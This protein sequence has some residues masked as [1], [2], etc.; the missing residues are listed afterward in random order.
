MISD[1]EL[2]R[3]LR[4]WL[5]E[6]AERAPMDRVTAALEEIEHVSQRRSRRAWLGRTFGLG[7]EA[8]EASRRPRST[9][10][11]LL[12]AMIVVALAMAVAIGLGGSRPPRPPSPTIRPTAPPAADARV[13]SD[14]PF[15]RIG[16]TALDPASSVYPS[17]SFDGTLLGYRGDAWWQ[18]QDG[19]TWTPADRT[20]FGMGGTLVP[21]G[22]GALSVVSNDGGG[23]T[24]G[25][26]SFREVLH[27]GYEADPDA[28]IFRRDGAGWSKLDIP[29]L[30][31]AVP[32][33]L[34]VLGPGFRMLGSTKHEWSVA[35]GD[36]KWVVPA[37]HVLKVDWNSILDIPGDE[38][39]PI[40]R[41]ERGGMLRIYRPGLDTDPL[42]E[43]SVQVVAGDPPSIEF[44]DLASGAVVHR[45][46]A[47]LR[48]WTPDEL[49]TAV[50]GWGAIDVS[51]VVASDGRIQV[52]HPPWPPTE[53][54][55]DTLVTARGRYYTQ[56]MVIGDRYAGTELHIW[57][58]D[59]GIT[60]ERLSSP[61]IEGDEIE[62][63]DLAGD[64][65]R[66]M[67]TIDPLSGPQTLWTSSDGASW[68]RIADY[69]GG[70]I[71][72]V[73]SGWMIANG[74]CKA[75]LSTDGRVWH[76][77]D[78][79]PMPITGDQ[80]LFEVDGHWF[81]VRNAEDGNIQGWVGTL[82]DQP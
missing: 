39:W 31:P 46:A 41:P 74:C 33:G 68:E 40:W 4:A 55:M 66:L 20:T 38:L 3:S 60:W 76:T 81:Y 1:L 44:R 34:T 77:F 73:R 54:W 71:Q 63:A 25:P 19:L 52:V 49:A 70:R 22:S 16:W 79:P 69:Q 30:T 64:G 18:S 58:S 13:T 82:V 42:R 14:T 12:L 45:I 61:P 2:D 5:T 23:I 26:S 29:G 7:D 37:N 50:R 65:E 21:T 67:L 24:M 57:G 72:T 11:L 36:D 51:F 6:P 59:D 35:L 48:G 27:R 80:S 9:R 78:L 43:L 53:E 75:S 32:D 15:G 56:T 10:L 28:G 8:S 17:T 47:T 62:L